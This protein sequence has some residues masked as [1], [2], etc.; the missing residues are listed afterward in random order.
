MFTK[1]IPYAYIAF[2]FL[3]AHTMQYVCIDTVCTIS[4]YTRY[5]KEI[6]NIV[7]DKSDVP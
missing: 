6:P 2:I 3:V 1:L 4:G 7:T 5:S